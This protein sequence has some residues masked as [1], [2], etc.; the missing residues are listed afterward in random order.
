MKQ[1]KLSALKQVFAVGSG[2][3]DWQEEHRRLMKDWRTQDLM[4]SIE[5]ACEV[6][7]RWVTDDDGPEVPYM[8]SEVCT[9]N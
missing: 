9:E 2:S 5:A 8:E 7:P 6:Y 1:V 4:K 3:W